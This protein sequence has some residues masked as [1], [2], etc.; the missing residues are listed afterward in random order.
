[1]SDAALL[2]AARA[3]APR[4]RPR[5]PEIEAARRLPADLVEELSRAGLFGMAVPRAI[6][7]GEVAPLT[8]IRAIEEIARADGSAGW[9]VMVGAATGLLAAYLEE[10]VAREIY[11]DP[12]VVTSGVFAPMG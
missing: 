9:C 8:M 5:S 11:G 10:D 3:L 4:I 6:G 7:G 12:R 2:E 1:M